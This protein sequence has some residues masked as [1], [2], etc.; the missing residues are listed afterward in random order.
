MPTYFYK[1]VTSSGKKL[2]GE[3]EAASQS[4][5][6]EKLQNSGHIPISAIEASKVKRNTNRSFKLPRFNNG[7]LNANHITIMT[8][9][10]A[11]LLHAGLPLD[12]AL[13]TL[14]GVSSNPVVASL[15]NN[16]YTRVQGGSSL[17]DAMEAQGK[18]FSRLY[19]NMI[20]AGEAGG[21]LE[22]VLQRLSDYLERSAEMRSTIISA[23]IYPL[24]LFFIAIISV[25]ALMVFVVP[26]FVPL[27]EDVGQALPLSTQLVFGTAELFQSFWWAFPILA[28]GGYWLFQRQLEDPEKRW[29]WDNFLLSI[30]LYGELISKIE[31][32][33][34]SRTLGTLLSNGVPLLMGV[35]IVRE[36][37][38]NRIIAEVM[39]T[40]THNLEQ[41]GR[42]AEALSKEQRFPQLAIQLIAVGEETGQLENMLLKI[43]DIY[44]QE[45]NSLIKRMLTLVEPVLILGLGGMIAVI[46]LSI[47][48]AIL[49]LN[50]LVV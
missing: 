38:N 49:G 25:I 6:I 11:T 24:I 7:Q 18:S 26:Q 45:T 34:F 47:L 16:I 13:Q 36:V 28:V 2:E 19:L 20:R 32:S 15:V 46:I 14:E 41:G 42:L 31:V 35:S 33:R 23:L 29:R 21:A 22:V 17:S 5:A 27:F 43:A 40:V 12:Q 50:E 1:A 3:M 48:V 44:D 37:I 39:D 9:E 8:R 10:L 30:P 4:I